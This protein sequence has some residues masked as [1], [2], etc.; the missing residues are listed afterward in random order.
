MFYTYPNSY[1][2][3]R[4]LTLF[5]QICV[6]PKKENGVNGQLFFTFLKS[7]M[8]VLETPFWIQ[9]TVGLVVKIYLVL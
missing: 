4:G 2:A 1:T 8:G 3:D 9:I 6:Y 5:G 7:D